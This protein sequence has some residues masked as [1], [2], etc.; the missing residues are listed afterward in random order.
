L[1][2]TNQPPG[3]NGEGRAR[4]LAGELTILL[5][6][7]SRTLGRLLRHSNQRLRLSLP[8]RH[9]FHQRQQQPCRNCREPPCEMLAN[10]TISLSDPL[11]NPTTAPAGLLVVLQIHNSR[12]WHQR[13]QRS[14][15]VRQLPQCRYQ[16]L[17][18]RR[19]KTSRPTQ[20]HM[21]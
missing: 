2:K 7:N 5:L 20:L 19:R 3:T 17:L 14:P 4:R 9:S 18:R 21:L 10:L 15:R 13:R 1:I 16:T 6:H 12:G 8:S 11:P